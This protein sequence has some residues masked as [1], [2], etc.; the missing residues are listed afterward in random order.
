MLVI[1]GT[2]AI[3]AWATIYLEPI[4]GDKGTQFGV[5]SASWFS[6]LLALLGVNVFCAVIRF[7]W[8]RH[9]TGFVITH[10]GILVLLFG[11]YLTRKG[12]IDAQLSVFRRED[13]ARRPRG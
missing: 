12:G 6:G 7:P 11:C 9:Q 10:L 4:Y 1:F 3:L 8:K 2:A 13:V 5:Y